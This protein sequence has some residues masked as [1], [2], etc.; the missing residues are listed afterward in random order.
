MHTE[1]AEHVDDEHHA[2]SEPW[3]E[4][5]WSWL[6]IAFGVAFVVWID[7]FMPTW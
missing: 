2:H 6:V 5:N 4:R 3:V 1:H 7:T